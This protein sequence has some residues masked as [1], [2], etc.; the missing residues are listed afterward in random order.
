[1]DDRYDF[2]G[3]INLTDIALQEGGLS[4]ELPDRS[5]GRR[6]RD[7]TSGY[8]VQHWGKQ[9]K[10]FPADKRNLNISFLSKRLLKLEGCI[11]TPEAS[12][13]NQNLS[14]RSAVWSSSH[15][16]RPGFGHQI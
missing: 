6:S 12:A 5:N 11:H 2:L 15:Y 7:T 1:M 3:K 10:V 4:Q 13:K 14:H 8:L 9:Q 16:H